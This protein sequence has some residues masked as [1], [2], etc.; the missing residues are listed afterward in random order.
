[1]RHSLLFFCLTVL[2][3]TGSLISPV[4]AEVSESDRALAEQVF[5]QLL[6][7]VTAPNGHALAA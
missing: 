5:H 6:V 3:L 4:S 2:L 1:M 7:S